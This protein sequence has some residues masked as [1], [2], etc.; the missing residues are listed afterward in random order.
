[1]LL[2]ELRPA[3]LLEVDL[4]TLLHHLG[5]GAAARAQLKVEISTHNPGRLPAD[6]QVA[7]YRIAQEAINNVIKHAQAGSLAISLTTP[8]GS[9]ENRDPG[10][11][12][13]DARWL[14]MTIVDDGRGFD[15]AAVQ[16]HRLGMGIMAERAASI[17]AELS[18]DSKPGEGTSVQVVWKNR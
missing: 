6:V 2:L 9:G 4:G 12:D 10:K 16:R 18:V 17:G 8:A 3:A 5:E 13:N 11:A 1:M 7:L 15:P 14:E